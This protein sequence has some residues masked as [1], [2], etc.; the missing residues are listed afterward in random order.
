M[1][2]TQM[3]QGSQQS[4]LTEAYTGPLKAK[5]A[6]LLD[7]KDGVRN[8]HTKDVMSVLAEN[9]SQYCQRQLQE[10]VTSTSI[11][12]Y[13][14]SLF[15]MFRRVFPNLIAN[16]VCSV[17][18]MNAKHGLAFTYDYKYGVRKGAKVPAGGIADN[19]WDMGYDGAV[20]SGD[21]LIANF[22][23]HYASEFV[24]YD[25]V[26]TDT[27]AA[28]ANLNNTSA[29][30]RIPGWKPIR[31]P[32]TEGQRTFSVKLYY[33]TVEGGSENKVATLDP[34]GATTNLIDNHAQVVGTFSCV[35]GA[36]TITPLTSLGVACNFSANDVIY[37]TYYVNWELISGTA[38]AVIPDISMQITTHQIVAE[39]VKLKTSWSAE[40]MDDLQAYQGMNVEAEMVAGIANEIAMQIDRRV[41]SELIAGA[42]HAASYAY[43]ATVPGEIESIRQLITQI[44]SV[45]ARIH[46]TTGR[47]MANFIVTSPAVVALFGQLTSHADFQGGASQIAASTYG[48]MTSDFGV[49]QVGTLLNKYV[50][51]QDPFMDDNKVLVGLRGSSFTD[52]GYIFAPYV[53]LRVTSTWHDPN[54]DTMHKGLSSRFATK[55]VRPEYYGVVTC[56][57][58]PTVTTTL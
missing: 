54:T 33:R 56:S 34:T 32:G 51:Y 44:D 22:A 55:L 46:K 17:Q 18:P 30:S 47:R 36:W 37:G 28:S 1:S 13:S 29:N 23:K 15:A 12:S 27:G 6:Q 10:D 21:S 41:L 39:S 38:G 43:A 5:W 14:K 24:D 26:C 7:G 57:G 50:V 2:A 31:T 25:V 19:A 8:P 20:A 40:A 9:Q 42:A 35:T 58:L 11:G 45:S 52:A 4:L 16:Q 49:V 53:P 3:I 48:P